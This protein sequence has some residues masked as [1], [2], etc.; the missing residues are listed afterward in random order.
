MVGRVEEGE[1]DAVVVTGPPLKQ[2]RDCDWHTL[3]SERFYVISQIDDELRKQGLRPVQPPTFTSMYQGGVRFNTFIAL[4]LAA[5]L[6]GDEGVA[7]VAVVSAVMIL[8]INVLCIAIFS[9]Y[10]GST[11]VRLK[12]IG[13]DLI[14]NPLLVGCLIGLGL[15][16]SGVGIGGSFESFVELVGKTA[17]PMGLM[18]V[19]AGLKLDRLRGNWEV[20][21]T[22]SLFQL[23]LKPLL[24]AAA[25]SVCGLQGIL[26]AA[27]LLCFTVPTA[28]SAYILS[29][30]KGGD[31]QT[32]AA[33]ITVQTL[34]S[35]LSIPLVV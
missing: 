17:L 10:I 4:V 11:Q 16:F 12:T 20:V 1:L 35:A 3:S 30:Q 5:Q 32:M 14:T 26:A 8:L 13:H 33:I 31:S 29:I 24:A 21:G 18:A 28:P 23:L 2:A 15:N 6:Y 34:L 25:V 7:A 22:A 27:L 19:G 9:T